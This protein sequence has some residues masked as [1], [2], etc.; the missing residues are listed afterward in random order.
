[1]RLLADRLLAMPPT[2]DPLIEAARNALKLPDRNHAPVDGDHWRGVCDRFV[3][4]HEE[5]GRLLPALFDDPESR[6]AAIQVARAPIVPC[7]IELGNFAWLAI[8]T[9][10]ATQLVLFQKV[11]NMAF[12]WCSSV[13]SDRLRDGGDYEVAF[14]PKADTVRGIK[15]G[16]ADTILKMQRLV[17]FLLAAISSHSRVAAA[18]RILPSSVDRARQASAKRRAQRGRPVFSYNRVEFVRPYTAIHR[19]VLKPAE[20]F[21]GMRG[22]FVIG[23]WRLI[24]NELQPYWTWVDGHPRGDESLGH[25]TK[26]RG[27]DLSRIIGNRR[28]FDL[29]GFAGKP[30]QRVEARRAL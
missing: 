4:D 1:M 22:H 24:D 5:C 13:L 12:P 3:F 15:P 23:H 27:V 29:P 21:A 28:G 20:S 9:P 18:R 19:G 8:G 7:W 2:S 16:V 26:E 6:E 17:I 10:E 30:G 11:E 25:V 14:T